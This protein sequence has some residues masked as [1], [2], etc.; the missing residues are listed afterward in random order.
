M[1]SSTMVQSQCLYA[2][3]KLLDFYDLEKPMIFG[4][5][6]QIIWGTRTQLYKPHNTGKLG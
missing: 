1:V 2:H 6:N 3:S 5:L 4:T